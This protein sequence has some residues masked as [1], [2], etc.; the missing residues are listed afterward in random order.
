MK[1]TDCAI[2]P[3]QSKL[4]NLQNYSKKVNWL[5]FA[6]LSLFCISSWVSANSKLSTNITRT[7]LFLIKNLLLSIGIWSELPFYIIESPEGW[8][9]TSV[10]T[11][12]AQIAQVLPMTVFL[13]LRHY[14]PD[15]VT[16]RKSIYF[17]LSLEVV[18][19]FL[20]GFFWNEKIQVGEEKISLGLY[21]LSFTISLLC[22][23]YV[24]N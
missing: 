18:A 7:C 16:Y 6:L 17:K 9:L 11:V 21:I 14:F 2:Q 22:K 8:R 23:L 10:L 15:Q 5:L 13:G 19:C 3:I 4:R 1:Q 24:M 12:L 20:L